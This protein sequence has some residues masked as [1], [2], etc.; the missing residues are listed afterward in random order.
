V[1]RVLFDEWRVSRI[2]VLYAVFAVIKD[3]FYDV[4]DISL[5]S[6][7]VNF[8]LLYNSDQLKIFVRS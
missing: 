2:L 3:I 1:T 7:S 6:S 5:S 8:F 4:L